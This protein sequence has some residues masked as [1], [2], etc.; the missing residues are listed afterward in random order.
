MLL[1]YGFAEFN[2]AVL[3]FCYNMNHTHPYFP[4]GSDKACCVT[5][6]PDPLPEPILYRLNTANGREE[7]CED[8][9]S[10]SLLPFTE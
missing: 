10:F 5:Q 3:H 4:T 9:Y 8:S 7:I 2:A 6:G 1:L